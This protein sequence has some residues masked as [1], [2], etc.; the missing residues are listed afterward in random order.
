LF[1]LSSQAEKAEKEARDL[2][3]TMRK[4]MEFLDFD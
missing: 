3:G 2:K 4:R 1:F